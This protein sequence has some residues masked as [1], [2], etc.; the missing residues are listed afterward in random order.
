MK[1]MLESAVEASSREIKDKT[2]LSPS[3]I[4]IGV[5]DSGLGG[6]TV[7]KALK[8]VIQNADLYYVADTL[9]APYGDKTPAQILQYSLDI[10]QYFIDTYNID[11]LILAC[12][13]ATSSSINKLRELYPELIIIGTEPGLKPAIEQ[14]KTGKIGVLATAATLDGIKYQA[15][16]NKLSHNKNVD[17]Y[18]QACPGLVEQIEAGNITSLQTKK[19]LESWL[20]PMKE[21]NVDTIVLGCTHYPLVAEVISK[22]MFFDV[23]L[24]DTGVAI[25]KRLEVLMDNSEYTLQ[26]SM[27]IYIESTGKINTKLI[28]YILDTPLSIKNISLDNN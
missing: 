18:E 17:L 14:T 1:E 23:Q 22:I 3:K 4:R 12:N 16:S 27:N 24:I 11:A 6:L 13:T 15:L 20:L 2:S 10:A 8:S 28:E 26:G 9:N 5:F 19:L 21:K 25:A 7:V